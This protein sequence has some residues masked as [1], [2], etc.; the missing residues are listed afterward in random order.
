MA[1]AGSGY[2]EWTIGRGEILRQVIQKPLA[3]QNPNKLGNLIRNPRGGP[4]PGVALTV[5]PGSLHIEVPQLLTIEIRW[6][7]LLPHVLGDD[8]ATNWTQ[9]IKQDIRVN[10]TRLWGRGGRDAQKGAPVLSLQALDCLN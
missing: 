2:D 8:V 1:F 3:F 7:R 5:D 10:L 6:H 9:A 4:R